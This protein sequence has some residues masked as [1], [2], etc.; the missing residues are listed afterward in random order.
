[1]IESKWFVRYHTRPEARM[2][3]FCFAFAGGS[4]SAFREWH[5]LLPDW[6]DVCAV[7]YPG[8]ETRWGEPAIPDADVLA[9]EIVTGMAP[10]FGDLPFAFFGHSLGAMMS[11][12]VAR[13]LRDAGG[14]EPVKLLLSGRR[15]PP[16]APHPPILHPLTDAEFARE[17][18]TLNGT[19]PE[20]LAN[21]ELM[22]LLFPM[23]RAD[24]RLDETYVF[25]A[26]EP[27]W[28]D[29]SIF[30]GAGDFKVPEGQLRSWA[31]HTTGAS[32]FQR[33]AGD[34]FYLKDTRSAMFEALRGELEGMRG[35]RGWSLG[36]SGER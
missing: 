23:L 14:A 10:A 27:L 3:L 29:F 34:H 13:R 17:M 26:G 18:G 1:M 32:R 21:R 24:F 36:Q 9:D 11:F 8:R 2:R 20:V 33:F 35:V 28:Q 25:R 12:E 7:Q 16:F 6:V 19:P 15:A 30:G 4:A 22:A 31:E 5:K